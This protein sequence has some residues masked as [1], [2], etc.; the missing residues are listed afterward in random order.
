MKWFENY[1]LS[2][3][4]FTTFLRYIPENSADARAI[5]KKRKY[6]YGFR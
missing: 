5:E 3:S 4:I 2:S 6:F 1:I